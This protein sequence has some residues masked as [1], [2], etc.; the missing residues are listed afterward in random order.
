MYEF[1][2]HLDFQL[3][4]QLMF[5]LLHVSLRRQWQIFSRTGTYASARL[6]TFRA[7]HMPGDGVAWAVWRKSH[8][9]HMEHVSDFFGVSQHVFLWVAIYPVKHARGE[10]IRNLELHQRSVL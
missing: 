2:I 10:E 1:L 3:P 5:V 8:F 9:A 7:A 6:K 4:K